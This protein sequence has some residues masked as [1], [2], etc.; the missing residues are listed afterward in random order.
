[1]ALR[2]VIIGGVAAGASA[3]ARAR[4]LNEDAEIVIFE[5]GGE[6]S[7]ANCGLPYFVGDIISRRDKL[8]LMTP[9][10]FRANF[11]IDVRVRHEVTQIDR[12]RKEVVGVNLATGDRFAQP[13]D[14][15]ILTMGA[16][17]IVPPIPGRDAPNV[18]AL[19]T[20]E[21]ADAMRAWIE[22][23]GA[24][25]AVLVGGGFIGLELAEALRTRGLAVSI[26][27]LADQLLPP[28]DPEMAFLL[29]EPLRRHGVDVLLREG[30]TEIVVEDGRA[31]GVVTSA[32]RRLAADLVV[33][34]I[35]VR[36]N[37]K[38][39][40]E[41]GLEL[42][43]TGGI[44]V[45]ANQQTSRPDILAAG[46]A[47][48]VIHAVT[49]KPVLIPLAGP[50]SRLGRLA[51]EFAATGKSAP[52]HRVLGT[53]GVQVFDRA[54]VITGLAEKT[55]RK[56]GL[57]VRSVT[58]RRGH[59][60]GYYP[61]AE[62][63]VLKLVWERGTRRIVSAQAVGGAGVDKRID[64]IA[65]AIH[66][67]ARID[68]LTG[69]DLVYAPQFGAAK[70]PVHIVAQV[71]VN[72]ED[73]VVETVEAEELVREPAVGGTVIDVRPAEMAAAGAIP[74]CKSI[75][76]VELRRRVEEIP[77]EGPVTVSCQV[78]QT[79]YV[80]ARVLM[81]MGR[82]NVRSLAGGYK[83]WCEATARLGEEAAS[84]VERMA[85]GGPQE[86]C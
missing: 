50:A 20:L 70:D 32:G 54:A 26:V 5:R 17:P 37:V 65:T 28:L 53:A 64:V 15:L 13:Y 23:S 58:I 60:V 51:G 79:S 31:V 59:H 84:R 24:R 25:S 22:R 4:R 29:I 81:G 27:E 6:V 39:A 18:F 7:F 55:A 80:A 56:A 44:K 11:R 63:M 57:D 77:S 8:L 21:D 83:G 85:A 19:R 33:L 40:Q 47:V 9:E 66:F 38:L 46:D 78:G 71:A 12:A 82:R 36:P 69:L 75:P 72:V 43:A 14:R 61:G 74:G 30:L 1:M 68:D 48:E 67:G 86:R 3:A 49:G 16:T 73:G 35:G 10:R 45:N 41:A 62:E 34:G 2:I 42:G 76:L 52:A